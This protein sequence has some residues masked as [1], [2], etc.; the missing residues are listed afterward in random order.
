MKFKLIKSTVLAN[1]WR[2]GAVLLAAVCLVW[3]AFI[4]S[5]AQLKTQKHVT[6]VRLGQAAEGAR[7]TVISDSTL[8]DYEAFR[9]GDRFYV[10]IPQAEFAIAQPRFHG[11]GFD[12]VQVQ[13]VGDSVVISF[14]LQPGASARVD[15]HSNR[16][17]IIF[18]APSRTQSGNASIAGNRATPASVN[19][20]SGNQGNQDR[21]R[22]AAGPVPSDGHQISRARFVNGP[23]IEGRE[24]PRQPAQTAKAESNQGRTKPSN[25]TPVASST[26]VNVASPGPAQN[27]PVSSSYTPATATSTPISSTGSKPV[28]VSANSAKTVREW[29]SA[30]RTASLFGALV[31][32]GLLALLAVV[33]YR[34]RKTNVSATRVQ[35]PLAQPKFDSKVELDELSDSRTERGP[36]AVSPISKAPEKSEWSRV[37]SRPA[38]APAAEVASSRA[39]VLSNP[40]VSSAV[41]ASSES[42]NKEREV[43]EL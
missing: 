16:L 32:V 43:F 23:R 12:D 9:R 14:K 3:V 25:N 4:S 37:V 42:V 19:R 11:D 15:E 6:S 20:S 2:Y 26:P 31:L 22:D 5:S 10:K 8:N 18:T 1:G 24:M 36:L 27:Y 7:V 33:L 28:G 41:V 17:D 40:S 21:Q 39:A 29:F 13:K 30:N 34:G 38:F 35:R